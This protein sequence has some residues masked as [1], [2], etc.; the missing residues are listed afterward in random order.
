M[1]FRLT[2]TAIV[3]VPLCL[4]CGDSNSSTEHGAATESG[5][6]GGDSRGSS[7]AT[8]GGSVRT[9]RVDG[10]AGMKSGEIVSVKAGI[11]AAD[12]DTEEEEAA[13]APQVSIEEAVDAGSPAPYSQTPFA[14]S[15]SSNGQ[16]GDE[17][18]HFTDVTAAAGLSSAQWQL[19]ES[20]DGY[21]CYHALRVSGGAAA[22]DIDDDGWTD[23]FVTRL[24]QPNQL[25]MNNGDGTF[26]DVAAQAGLDVTGW[27]NAPAFADIDGDSD[28]DLFV[29]AAGPAK[30]KLFINQG[31]GTFIEQATQRGVDVGGTEVCSEMTSATF[32]D[33]DHDGALDLYVSQWTSGGESLNFLF[34]N[35]GNGYF[36]NVTEAAGIAQVEPRGYSAGFMDFDADGWEDLFVVADFGY[37]QLFHN[38]RDGTFSDVTDAA[39]VALEEDGM[40]NALGDINGDGLPDWF[41]TNV[42]ETVGTIGNRLYIN[43]GD[44]SF[45]DQ[46][47]LYGVARGGWGWGAQMFDIDNDGQLDLSNVSG[48][49]DDDQL[50]SLWLG[51]SLPMR[52]V[53]AEVGLTEA[54][55]GRAYVAF[56]YDRDG[57]LDSFVVQNADTP[58]LYR[59][60]IAGD[61]HALVVRVRSEAPNTYGIGARVELEHP[62]GRIQY[63]WITGNSNFEGHGPFEAHFG[64]GD[65]TGPFT[66]RVH[67]PTSGKTFAHGL[68]EADQIITVEEP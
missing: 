56:D 14:N 39:G 16:N 36:E 23:L 47:D 59:N 5:I 54:I 42:F 34:H 38:N 43:R 17:P 19:P 68:V 64:L 1:T 60:D 12:E 50:P 67:W 33:Y 61:H 4:G 10:A 49:I 21:L 7:E 32:G 55:N 3:V 29:T 8:G 9:M 2:W 15:G 13:P 44:G 58:I 51:G 52:E 53:S 35:D 18:L 66:V 41:V 11:E 57:D 40:G 65:D 25:F 37:S 20:W 46:T 28:L 63:R 22:V 27:S 48:W 24:E 30:A 26:T 31:D 45:D 6:T 62:N